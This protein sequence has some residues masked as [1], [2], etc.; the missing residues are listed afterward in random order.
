MAALVQIPE[1]AGP[2]C[3]TYNLPDLKEPL[4]LSPK[5]LAGIYL[6]QIK[7]WQ[8]AALKKDNA[9]VKLPNRPI[10]VA[11]RSD[12]SGTTNIF[13]TYLDKVSPEWAKQSRQRDFGQLAHRSWRQRQRGRYRGGTAVRWHHRL[14]RVVLRERKQTAHGSSRE[15][16]R[17]FR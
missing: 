12:G 14:C 7:T 17:Q 15:P 9:G 5:T 11:H 8:D 16:G 6:G 13:T 4:K 10:I 2:V 1:S 3:I